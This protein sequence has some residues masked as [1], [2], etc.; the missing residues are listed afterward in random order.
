MCAAVIAV[1]RSRGMLAPKSKGYE[2]LLAALKLGT[3]CYI[4]TMRPHDASGRLPMF[5]PNKS[6]EYGVVN[7]AV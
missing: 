3:E 5:P 4:F 2:S 1:A 6:S 7:P